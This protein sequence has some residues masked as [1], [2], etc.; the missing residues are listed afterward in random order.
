MSIASTLAHCIADWTARFEGIGIET[1]ALDARTLAL[2]VCGLAQEDLIAN[3]DLQITEKEFERFESLCAR[4]MKFEPIAYLTGTKEFWS[5]E[6]EVG[7]GT[8]IP[9][10]DSETLVTLALE[11]F[12]DRSAPCACLILELEPDAC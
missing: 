9:R 10:P 5:L 11:D 4:R 7:E 3:P 1:A 6:F 12:L 8:L 2:F